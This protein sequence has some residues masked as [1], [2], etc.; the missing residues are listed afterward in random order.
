[1]R[2]GVDNGKQQAQ[3]SIVVCF[4][5]LSIQGESMK[6]IEAMKQIKSLTIKAEDL[7]KKVSIHC[8]DLDFETPLYPDQRGQVSEWV[9]AH[10]DVLKEIAIQRTNLQTNV[11][12]QLGDKTVTKSMA[13]WIHRR[14]DLSQLDLAAWNALGDRN[15]KEGQTQTTQGEIRQVRIRRYFDPKER[16]TKVDM[17]RSEPMVIDSTLEVVNAVTDLIE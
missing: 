12:I 17:Y 1:L 2:K 4:V 9:Q 7:R 8:A 15:L 11:S 10:S 3:N 16:D 13:E 5:V 14:R 6:V